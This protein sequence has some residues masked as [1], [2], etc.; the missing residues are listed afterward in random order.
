MKELFVS[1]PSRGSDT[2]VGKSVDER[3]ISFQ[4]VAI[5]RD[6]ALSPVNAPVTLFKVWMTVH[7]WFLVGSYYISPVQHQVAIAAVLLAH[8]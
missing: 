3:V 7:V 1:F 2:R 5:G 4:A 6:T 8:L